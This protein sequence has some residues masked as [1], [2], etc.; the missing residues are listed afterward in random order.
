MTALVLIWGPL[1]IAIIALVFVTVRY[2][3]RRVTN[4][5]WPQRLVLIA[6]VMW[7]VGDVLV[8][9][10]VFS[11]Y[12]SDSGYYKY[13]VAENVLGFYDLTSDGCDLGCS[14]LLFSHNYEFI[15]AKMEKL[16]FWG[17]MSPKERYADKLVPGPGLYRFT[18]EKIGHPNCTQ[19]DAWLVNK[20]AFTSQAV[21]QENCIATQRILNLS[22][23][24]EVGNHEVWKE[25]PL[26]KLRR[27]GSFVRDI[28]T[29]NLLMESIHYG[30][31]PKLP[32][33]MFFRPSCKRT[34]PFYT[35]VDVLK[36]SK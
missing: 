19:Y 28:S 15:E 18:L 29:G 16:G 3:S 22:A 34:G 25:T 11:Q 31:Q 1:Y 8:T 33:S 26:G 23:Q 21:Y 4:S 14:R 36:N 12:C 17:D 9:K 30:F 24:Y 32:W 5:K 20:P 10:Y 6:A 13:S 7:P 35:Y 2:V 27:D